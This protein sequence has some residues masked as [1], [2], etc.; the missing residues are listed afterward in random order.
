MVPVPA[1]LQPRS[2]PDRDGLL[3]AEGADQEAAA[4]TYDE[5]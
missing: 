2:Q 4:R 3:K 5:L 1:A